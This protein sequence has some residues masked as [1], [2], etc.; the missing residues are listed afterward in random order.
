MAKVY[1]TIL[2]GGFGT[3]LWPLS[4]PDHPKQFLKIF[5]GSSLFQLTVERN[6]ALVDATMI[7][8]NNSHIDFAKAQMAELGKEFDKQILEPVPRNTAPA[9][10]LAALA[11]APE[12]ILFVTP[13]D[14]MISDQEAYDRCVNRAL[15]L[16]ESDYLV[17][18]SIKPEYPE[19]GYGY[20]EFD[21]ENVLSF[22]EKPDLKTAKEFLKSG[23]FYWNSGMFCFKAGVF[24]NELKLHSPEIYEASVKAHEKGI[25]VET[26]SA[27]PEDSVDYAVFEKS[28]RIKTVPSDF[29]WQDLGNFDSL[30]S[31]FEKCGDLNGICKEVEGVEN[32]NCFALAKKKVLGIGLEDMI[33][34]ETE[35]EILILPRKASQKV[36]E[37]YQ[38]H[39]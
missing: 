12:D 8:T 3:R 15:E 7:L 9:I 11:V 27:I 34:V 24:L 1:H 23:N 18:F 36:K 21:Q 37:I 5:N 33:V 22:R 10:A 32:K 16:A 28:T 17:T 39:K 4:R 31:Y 13:S 35:N 38:K 6:T 2:S 29:N 14:H 19:T 25:T 20:I 30:V 26:M